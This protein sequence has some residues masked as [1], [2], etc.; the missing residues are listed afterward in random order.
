M[1]PD[2]SSLIAEPE[3]RR[4]LFEACV[5]RGATAMLVVGESE[6]ACQARFQAAEPDH[7]VLDLGL[8]L[9]AGAATIA[10]RIHAPCSVVFFEGTHTRFFLANV[11]S[12]APA[13][14]ER[15]ARIALF[16]PRFVAGTDARMAYRVP[17]PDGD[18]LQVTLVGDDG[19]AFHPRAENL[20]ASGALLC[21]DHNQAEP[22]LTPDTELVLHFRRAGLQCAC[23]A[24]LVRADGR[25]YA[26]RFLSA[27]DDPM[28]RLLRALEKAW[29]SRNDRETVDLRRRGTGDL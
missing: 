18:E 5:R 7:L 19:E 28:E 14:S 27:P 20:S 11:R 26:F 12:F 16:L 21:F 25:R 24:A 9:D 10:G 2:H 13:S 22:L 8:D 23:P 6:L 3:E 1:L 15:P 29:L 4:L 17:V